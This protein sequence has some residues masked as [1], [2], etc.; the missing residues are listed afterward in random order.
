MLL[1]TDV[2]PLSDDGWGVIITYDA[3]GYVSDE[4]AENIDYGKLL[5]QMQEATR[6]ASAERV[7]Q[8]YE[9]MELVR[10]A[11]QPHYDKRE[12]KLYWAKVLKFGNTSEET[13]NYNIRVLGRRG[14]L[15][16]NAV[17]SMSSMATIDRAAPVILSMVSFNQGNLYSEFNPHLDEVAAYGL[18]GLIAGGL[19]TKA[20]FF[21][22]LI[23]LLLASKKL[24]AIGV[25]AVFAGVW[26][27]IK[28]LF[29]RKTEA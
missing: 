21:K 27:G 9:S 16:L 10:W 18:A 14:V 4:D 23:A 25:I 29:R 15:N 8:G 3:S 24:V 7:K 20:G 6:L 13:L 28:S 17:A 19:L 26:G 22:G 2:N 5:N 12:K 11:R 1:P